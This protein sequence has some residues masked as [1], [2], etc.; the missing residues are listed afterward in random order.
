MSELPLTA[1]RS[2]PLN[3]V[4][5][6]SD[7]TTVRSHP[8]PYLSRRTLTSTLPSD[9]WNGG[10][11][12]AAIVCYACNNIKSNWAWRIPMIGQGSYSIAVMVLVWF[13][14]EVS[15][16][17]SY[18][19]AGSSIDRSERSC[20]HLDG[21]LPTVDEKKRWLSLSNTTETETPTLPWSSSRCKRWRRRSRK[22]PAVTRGG[23]TTEVGGKRSEDAFG[24]D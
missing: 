22:V 1:L 17:P 6:L 14:P 13:L 12:P 3:G 23:G 11:I 15:V 4:V 20:S 5:D 8:S 19:W 7:Y 18:Y 2:R 16:K 21:C 24:L 9:G 10:A